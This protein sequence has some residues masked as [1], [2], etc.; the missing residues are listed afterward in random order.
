M[1]QIPYIII[2]ATISTLF[3]CKEKKITHIV[4]PAVIETPTPKPEP[5]PEPESK[6]ELPKNFHIVAGCFEQSNNASN[7]NSSLLENGYKSKI[8]PF[9]KYS[10]VTFGDYSTKEEAQK[11]L[12]KLAANNPSL[13][14]WIY[15]TK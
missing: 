11:E 1:K 14:V 3:S 9:Y 2:L 13:G 7:L 10:M 12:N 6:P 5:K 4:H 8:M 15:E